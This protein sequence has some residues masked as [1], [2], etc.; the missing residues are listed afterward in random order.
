MS[1]TWKWFDMAIVVAAV[2][3]G[4][5]V[6]F[7]PNIENSEDM[8]KLV[9][10]DNERRAAKAANDKRLAEIKREQDELGLVFLSPSEPKD[11]PKQDKTAT[12]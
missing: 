5:A 7:I 2:A 8:K 4:F 3:I 12:Q 10:I 6:F 9:A 1:W 11:Q